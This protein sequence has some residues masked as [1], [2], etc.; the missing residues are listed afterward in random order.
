[1]QMETPTHTQSK[2]LARAPEHHTRKSYTHTHLA[3][4]E[5]FNHD[6]SITIYITFGVYNIAL[7][8]LWV[9]S[10]MGLMSVS[11]SLSLTQHFALEF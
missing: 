9:Q 2:R 11:V 7:L 8:D 3:K 4:I 1:M 10:A 6:Q 5:W